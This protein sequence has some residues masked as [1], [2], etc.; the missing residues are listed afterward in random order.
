MVP[1]KLPHGE[2]GGCLFVAGGFVLL[3]GVRQIFGFLGGGLRGALE[4][5]LDEAVVFYAIFRLLESRPT[6]HFDICIPHNYTAACI[7]QFT[8]VSIV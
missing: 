4:D 1:T 7:A 5:S 2:K 6:R 8:S 3:P